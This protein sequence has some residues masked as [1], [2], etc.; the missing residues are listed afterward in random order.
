M[1][2]CFDYANDLIVEFEKNTGVKDEIL[3]GSIAR[4]DKV[5]PGMLFCYDVLMAAVEYDDF[6][7]YMMSF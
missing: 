1:V 7:Q 2:S 3:Y 5:S 6:V 4:M